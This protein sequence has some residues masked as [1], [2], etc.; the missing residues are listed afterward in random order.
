MLRSN[1]GSTCVVKVEDSDDS[2]KL[3]F[4]SFYICF[5]ACKKAFV[6]GCR[7]CIGLDGCF[8]KGVTKGQLLVAVAK[9]DNNQMLPISWAVVQYENKNTWT[10]FVKL[11]IEDLGLTNDKDYTIIQICKRSLPIGE[12]MESSSKKES[13]LEM[14]KKHFEAEMKK[15][16]NQLAML[17][18][19][20]MFQIYFI[21][22]GRPRKTTP[23]APAG[24]ATPDA[25]IEH[26][27]AAIRGRGRVD[28]HI[29]H[30]AATA[31][32]RR[33]GVK[34]IATTARERGRG[35]EHIAATARERGGGIE[36]VA[37]TSIERKKGVEHT[38]A[39]VI[40]RGRG[41]KHAAAATRGR[42]RGFEHV[43]AAA[44]A[45]RGRGRPRITPLSDIGV[46]RRTPLYEWFE[47]PTSYAPPNPP[48]SP[49][50]DPPNPSASPIHTPLN[51]HVST[52]KRPKTVGIGI[53]IAENG[54]TTYNPGFPSSRIIHTGSTHPIRFVDITGDL[55]YKPKTGQQYREMGFKKYSE[56]IAHLLVAEQHN[57]LL[58]KTNESR[59]PGTAP[60]PEVNAADFRPTR[61]ERSPDPQPWSWLR[62]RS[63]SRLRTWQAMSQI[64][65]IYEFLDVLY[66][67]QLHHLSILRWAPREDAFTDLKSITKSH[68]PSVNVPVRIE[69][70]KEPSS[71]VTA[72]ESQTRLKS[73]RP[74][75]SKDKNPRKRSAKNNKDGI[76]KDSPKETQN[77]IN[78]DIP[79]EISE[80]ET[81]VNEELSISST[82]DEVNL[83]R[84]KIMVDNIFGYY[85]ALNI[86][87][88]N[89]DL[90]PLSVEE[91]RRRK[92]GQN[93]KRRFNLN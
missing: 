50:Y 63:R 60:F 73:V 81:Q 90:E 16:L 93:S 82:N 34:H 76:I 51:P 20:D 2:C 59:P 52:G 89:E 42:G 9:D 38:A 56:L 65:L 78:P 21:T 86:M 13:V 23:A 41:V 47:N 69:V 72:S 67:Y 29:E 39:A 64:F 37:A 55:G 44:V 80:P 88:D 26:V 3:V 5:D 6:D 91:C 28:E 92:I 49:V 85:V 75:G 15:N 61:H 35:V 68:I 7:R 22:R 27:A 4:Q 77:L 62:L 43:A 17:G 33:K 70:P 19:E 74:L 24:Q 36:H 11:L 71:N 25:N 12:K 40:E 31:R 46:S 10:W 32:E 79:E 54:L 14:C 8:L 48:T 87:Q 66:M 84:S 45:T 58:I 30:V 83:D 1:S 57:E 53:L 18:G